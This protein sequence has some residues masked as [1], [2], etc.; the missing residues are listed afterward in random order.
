M[1]CLIVQMQQLQTFPRLGLS[2][3]GDWPVAL[4]GF[5]NENKHSHET[6]FVGAKHLVILQGRKKLSYNG[7]LPWSG[8]SHTLPV[9]VWAIQSTLCYWCMHHFI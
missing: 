6:K 5:G 2:T 1:Q 9:D 3:V 7:I 4:W 8:C